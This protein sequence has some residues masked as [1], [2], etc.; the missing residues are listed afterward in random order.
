[1]RYWGG[2]ACEVLGA[3]ARGVLGG[4][5]REVLGGAYEIQQVICWGR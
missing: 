4:V 3:V 2:V 1:M 5:A